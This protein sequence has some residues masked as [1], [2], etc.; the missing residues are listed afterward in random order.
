MS[1][2]REPQENVPIARRVQALWVKFSLVVPPIEMCGTLYRHQIGIQSTY[3][4]GWEGRPGKRIHQMRGS[5]GMRLCDSG[6][7]GRLQRKRG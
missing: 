6:K 7:P 5:K 4:K 2:L 3:W 1:T